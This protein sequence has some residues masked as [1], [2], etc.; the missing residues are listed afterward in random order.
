MS[1]NPESLILPLGI[2][3]SDA[4]MNLQD[5]G[6]Q[7]TQT[8]FAKCGTPRVLAKREIAK[9]E[10]AKSEIAKREIA[11]REIA[12]REAVD[13]DDLFKRAARVESSGPKMPLGQSMD[14]NGNKG[15]RTNLDRALSDVRK[16][17]SDF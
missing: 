13:D 17:V 16:A 4:I 8:V 10:I 3:I 9:R 5:R 7:V 11:K 12:K 14:S 1:L 15:R 6:F 2:A